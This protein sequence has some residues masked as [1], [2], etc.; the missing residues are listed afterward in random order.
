[1]VRSQGLKNTSET[2]LFNVFSKFGE[3]KDIRLVK[4]KITVE[5][6]DFAFV[7]FYTL[8]EAKGCIDR[9]IK[10]KLLLNNMEVAVDFSKN[11]KYEE[12]VNFQVS[13]I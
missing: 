11:R 13:Y 4:D 1:M 6:K 2:E 5:N 8:D 3:I 7:E 10:D 9:T 12:N